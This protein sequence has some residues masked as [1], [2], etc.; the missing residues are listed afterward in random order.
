MEGFVLTTSKNPINT[1]ILGTENQGLQIILPPGLNGIYIK[2]E[3]ISYHSENISLINYCEIERD[4]YMKEALKEPNDKSNLET[5]GTTFKIVKPNDYVYCYNKTNNIQY[6]GAAST[7]KI[8]KI[9]LEVEKYLYIN[10]RFIVAFDGTINLYKSQE[11]DNYLLNLFAPP[12]KISYLINDYPSRKAT[13]NE[14]YCFYY[15]CNL[16]QTISFSDLYFPNFLDSIYL[17]S[18][19]KFQSNYFLYLIYNKILLD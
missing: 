14:N 16:K 4:K 15:P 6:I 8:M 9:I 10:R 11:Y 17:Q 2:N 12:S 3:L 7:G 13:M 5:L 19:S 18:P 1:T